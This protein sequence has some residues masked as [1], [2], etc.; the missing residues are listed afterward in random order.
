MEVSA[1]FW[2]NGCATD[3]ADASTFALEDLSQNPSI[4][5][6]RLGK[7]G[8]HARTSN[9]YH[10]AKAYPMTKVDKLKSK[11]L[12]LPGYVRAINAHRLANIQG[13]NFICR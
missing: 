11:T 10:A 13:S 4:R 3:G 6:N 12:L 2:R 8:T 1:T 7:D 5:E 9:K